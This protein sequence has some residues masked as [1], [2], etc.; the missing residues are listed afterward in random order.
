MAGTLNSFAQYIEAC[1]IK[2][3]GFALPYFYFSLVFLWQN[4]LYYWFYSDCK[5]NIRYKLKSI[6][7][8]EKVVICNGSTENHLWEIRSKQIVFYFIRPVIIGLFVHITHSY[9]HF[10][11]NRRRGQITDSEMRDSTTHAY[12]CNER[13]SAVVPRNFKVYLNGINDFQLGN[14]LSKFRRIVHNLNKLK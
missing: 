14:I 6:V 10:H 9:F 7:L 13:N 1:W 4:A 5:I 3:S 12:T 11:V 2:P 8:C